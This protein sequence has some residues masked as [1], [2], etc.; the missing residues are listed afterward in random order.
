MQGQQGAVAHYDLI[1]NILQNFLAVYQLN[2]YNTSTV[3]HNHL[4]CLN[5]KLKKEKLKWSYKQIC[6]C[7]LTSWRG[8]L[9]NK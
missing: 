2:K 9:K 5:L 7:I 3:K 1:S 6:F 4:E 8:N